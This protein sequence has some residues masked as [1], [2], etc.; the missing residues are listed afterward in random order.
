L[1]QR[2]APS[3]GLGLT[4]C[5]V[6]IPHFPKGYPGETLKI[7]GLFNNPTDFRD[8]EYPS[9]LCGFCAP[10]KSRA[11]R[12]PQARRERLRRGATRGRKRMGRILA[13]RSD[14]THRQ[15]RARSIS[16]CAKFISRFTKT[17]SPF[18]RNLFQRRARS[19]AQ[20]G[21]Y[22]GLDKSRTKD[23]C[24]TL[25]QHFKSILYIHTLHSPLVA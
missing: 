19:E 2:S 17:K 24:W 21:R 1:R 22:C 15:A 4:S 13:F 14:Q 10:H 8:I 9:G 18:A 23:F 16:F 3:L 6:E 5:L 7:L 11:R 12:S 25:Y 20:R